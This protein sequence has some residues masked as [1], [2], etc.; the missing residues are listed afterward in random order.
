MEQE[1]NISGKT[2][3]TYPEKRNVYILCKNEMCIK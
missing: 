3:C 2:K 1:I